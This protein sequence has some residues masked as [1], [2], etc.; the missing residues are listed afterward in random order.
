MEIISDNLVEN[1]SLENACLTWKCFF[2]KESFRVWRF[3]CQPVMH[4][5][6]HNS[7]K[8]G[9]NA[10]ELHIIRTNPEER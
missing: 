10:G 3:Q 4:F 6:L 1:R 2:L 8:V 7:G 5:R 9:K